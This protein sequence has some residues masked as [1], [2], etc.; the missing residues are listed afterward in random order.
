MAQHPTI[1]SSIVVLNTFVQLI[2]D[3]MSSS[4]ASSQP[5]SIA[6]QGGL[7]VDEVINPSM[8]AAVLWTFNCHK[9]PWGSLMAYI[10][11]DPVYA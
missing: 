3:V 9:S 4:L 10:G 7:I 2:L 1:S 8:N 5:K 6:C 11:A